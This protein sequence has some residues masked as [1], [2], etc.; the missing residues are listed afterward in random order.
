[1]D[2]DGYPTDTT[3]KRI[4]EWE[5]H[6]GDSF[7]ALIT[8]LRSI[9]RWPTYITRDFDGKVVK[10]HTGGWSGHEEIIGALKDNQ[11]FWLLCWQ[12]SK[13]G[14]HFVFTAPRVESSKL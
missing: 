14:G 6:D 10:I 12:S 4:R 1:M 13:R 3:L 5:I 2:S 11:L 9:W 7:D 8:F